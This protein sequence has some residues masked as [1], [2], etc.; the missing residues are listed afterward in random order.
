MVGR[1]E[2]RGARNK[3]LLA[4]MR[5][6]P[7]KA[8]IFAEIDFEISDAIRLAA[9]ANFAALLGLLRSAESEIPRL[10]QRPEFKY[11]P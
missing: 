9:A 8:Q 11:K 4:R 7:I 3:D 1:K 6:P 2:E 5:A 10:R